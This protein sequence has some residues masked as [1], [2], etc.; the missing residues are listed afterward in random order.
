MLADSQAT[1]A[2]ASNVTYH[3]RSSW[4]VLQL[5][6]SV[7]SHGDNRSASH[8]FHVRHH[9]DQQIALSNDM[10]A[11]LDISLPLGSH[12]GLGTQ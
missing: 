7:F 11:T 9:P 12:D 10:P 1:V 2:P 4:S 6:T 8:S 3:E 5:R